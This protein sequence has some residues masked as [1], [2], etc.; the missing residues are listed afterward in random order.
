MRASS[1]TGIG[2]RLT[3]AFH[4]PPPARTRGR[5]PI[6]AEQHLGRVALIERQRGR[7]ES[8]AV[9]DARVALRP[10]PALPF[11]AVVRRKFLRG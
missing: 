4:S 7:R 6:A 8:E 2:R 10:I 11:I 3:I 9:S 1:S 5:P